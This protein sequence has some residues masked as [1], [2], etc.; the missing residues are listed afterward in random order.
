MPVRIA[1]VQMETVP[2]AVEANRER[3][4]G[5]AGEALEHRP[6]IILFAEEMLVGYVPNLKELAEEAEGRTTREF[7]RLLTGSETLVLWGLTERERED[8]YITAALV[9]AGG[10]VAKYRK[11]HLWWK[12]EGLRHEPTYYRAG[13]NLVTF[14][15]KG[16]RSGVMICYD[17]D[18]PEVTRAYAARGCR[19]LFWLNN[20]EARG[21]GEVRDL[22]YRNSMII[23]ASCPTGKAES[24]G[25]CPGG[26]NVTDHRGRALAEIWDREGVIYADVRPE[27]VEGAR[28]EN[29]WYRGRRPEVYQE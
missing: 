15:V 24:G 9:G 5:F 6:D 10:L 17:G 20:R 1:V 2:G 11:T 14:E 12:S 27:E 4:L 13:E 7:A 25:H 21:H 16:H 3:A 19:M 28:G 18:F 8:C 29:P 22:A 26:S 23:A